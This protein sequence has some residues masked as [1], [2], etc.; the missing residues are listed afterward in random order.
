VNQTEEERIEAEKE[1]TK[2]RDKRIAA[3]PQQL[4]EDRNNA[5]ILNDVKQGLFNPRPTE[6][7]PVYPAV[8]RATPSPKI[9][10]IAYNDDSVDRSN[11]LGEFCGSPVYALDENSAEA[12]NAEFDALVVEPALAELRDERW[13][14]QVALLL[15]PGE[16]RCDDGIIRRTTTAEVIGYDTYHN[17]EATE[18][19]TRRVIIV[20]AQQ[21]SKDGKLIMWRPNKFV[22]EGEYALVAEE[23]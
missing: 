7:E 14:A 2:A 20:E 4:A 9:E 5:I 13:K 17:Q 8:M 6:L 1:R 15:L 3:L 21:A 16:E 19:G 10:R 23:N 11:V 22:G 18:A 12:I